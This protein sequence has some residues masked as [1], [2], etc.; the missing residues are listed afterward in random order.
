MNQFFKKFAVAALTLTTAIALN[1]CGDNREC[2]HNE[3]EHTLV[4]PEKT[5]KT[6]NLGGKVW[7][8]ENLDVFTPDSSI[9]YANNHDNCD[10]DGR[11]YTYA[12]AT[13]AVCPT[14]WAL[15]TQQD[16]KD[17]FAN[18]EP[19]A[20]KDAAGFNTIFAGFKYYDGNF[21]DKG[22]SASFWTSD[23]Y[24]DS[25]AYLVRITDT[26]VAYEHFNKN[27]FASVRCIKK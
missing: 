3:S 13:G 16:F 24:D 21:A 8:A 14:G 7:M 6:V 17:A 20:L 22:A 15:P 19:A 5:Y 18:K 4:C 11:L 1:A 25:R 27:I 9:C 2:S 12:S 10:T 26:S 23:S